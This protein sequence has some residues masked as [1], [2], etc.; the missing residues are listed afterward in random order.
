MSD[1]KVDIPND[2]KE[3]LDKNEFWEHEISNDINL[4]IENIDHE[5]VDII[6]YQ[7][8]I[9]G[10]KDGIDLENKFMEYI[11]EHDPVIQ[12]KISG[13]SES[14][15]FVIWTASK[16]TFEIIINYVLLFVAR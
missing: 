6:S 16:K 2:I 9:E 7:I 4:T 8:S 13:D 3:Y 11:S 1:L 14:S 12:K 5:G 10:V 15:T